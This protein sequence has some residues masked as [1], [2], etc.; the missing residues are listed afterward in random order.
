MGFRLFCDLDNVWIEIYTCIYIKILFMLFD[1][2]QSNIQIWM[3]L[4]MAGG[5]GYFK[6]VPIYRFWILIIVSY[7]QVLE[8]LLLSSSPLWTSCMKWDQE[9]LQWMGYHKGVKLAAGSNSRWPWYW[10]Q[11]EN[12]PHRSSMR[13]ENSLTGN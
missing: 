12:W 9:M 8:R 4:Q 3:Q 7:W 6:A 2:E 13:P 5:M 11:P 10:P 1:Q